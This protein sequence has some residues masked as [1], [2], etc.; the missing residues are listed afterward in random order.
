MIGLGGITGLGG[1][2]GLGGIKIGKSAPERRSPVKPLGSTGVGG[3][4][5]TTR[6]AYCAGLLDSD[7]AS[8]GVIATLP[9][10]RYVEQG[11]VGMPDASVSATFRPPA[12]SFTVRSIRC[13]DAPPGFAINPQ[14]ESATSP[15]PG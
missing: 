10:S 13:T 9:C 4:L 2:I 6:S 5:P 3:M 7:A 12:P 11:S 8:S 15:L 14:T 1:M